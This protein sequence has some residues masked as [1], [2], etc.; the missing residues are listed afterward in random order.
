MASVV[1]SLLHSLR[2]TIRSRVSLHLE[3]I[4]LRHQLAV[5]NRS[6]RPCLRLTPVDRMLWAW[7]SRSWRGWREAIHIVKPDTVIAWLLSAISNAATRQLPNTASNWSHTVS[8][9]H[10]LRTSLTLGADCSARGDGRW[11]ELPVVQSMTQCGLLPG[12]S[13]DQRCPQAGH[14]KLRPVDMR[15]TWATG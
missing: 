14:S 2:F 11:S 5:V 8:S 4:A 12:G 13:H 6:R 10:V 7:L 9:P 15:S 3:I 1:F